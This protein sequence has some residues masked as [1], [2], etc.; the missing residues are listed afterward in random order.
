MLAD[1]VRIGLWIWKPSWSI[2]TNIPEIKVK[3]E[4]IINSLQFLEKEIFILWYGTFVCLIH[5]TSSL[6]LICKKKN[7]HCFVQN[8]HITLFTF[9][10][11]YFHFVCIKFIPSANFCICIHRDFKSQTIWIIV[12][13]WE[14]EWSLVDLNYTRYQLLHF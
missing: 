1:N 2:Q 12:A 6:F 14:K 4:I 5:S 3:D 13:M 9:I 7:I 10:Y 8:S 11:I